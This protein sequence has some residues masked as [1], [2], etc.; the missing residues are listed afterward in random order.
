MDRR[1]FLR[2][3]ALATAGFTIA[4]NTILGKTYGHTSP[5]DKLNIAGIGIGGMGRRNL[6]NMNT[7][8]IVA[9]C[10]V[11][12][13]YATKTFNDYPNAKKYKDWRKLFDMMI[14]GFAIFIMVDAITPGA[15]RYA[16]PDIIGQLLMLN[17]LMPSPDKVIWPGPYWFFGLMLQVYAVYILL[18]RR[19]G[20]LSA[21]AVVVVCWGLQ[22]VC[23]P[24]GET[25]NRLRYNFIGSMLPFCAGLLYARY[26]VQIPR[27]I[28]TLITFLSYLSV[29]LCGMNFH[30]WLWAPLY[31][32]LAAVG[33]VKLMPVWLCI[34]LS[35]LGKL[36]AALFVIHPVA[37]KI[38]IGISR[39]GDV[40]AGLLLYIIA[41]VALAWATRLIINKMKKG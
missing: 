2:T 10:D 40:Y 13:G 27:P 9:L 5:S 21:V 4:P 31:V 37:R 17:N 7:E 39:R 20:W 22:V 25:L 29:I 28:W 36:S 3:A 8:N 12:W 18:L 34:K 35:H 30:L 32:C 6:A 38:F 23:D 16:V 24:Q 15:H 19:G 33:T 11:D 14:V 1:D 41:C 26:C